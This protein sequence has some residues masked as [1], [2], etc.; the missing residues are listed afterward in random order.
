MKSDVQ[1]IILKL[2]ADTG[3]LY[4]LELVA[5]SEGALKRGTVYVTLDRL[6]ESGL[7]ESKLRAPSKGQQGPSRR[8]YSITGLG[9]KVMKESLLARAQ[10]S[11]VLGLGGC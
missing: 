3:E 7:I 1:L 5:K 4:G 9:K 6:E 2:L 8:I 11:A 10:I